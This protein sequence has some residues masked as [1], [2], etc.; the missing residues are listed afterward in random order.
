MSQQNRVKTKV[1]KPKTAPISYKS[2]LNTASLPVTQSYQPAQYYNDAMIYS[3]DY[4]AHPHV[5]QY[6]GEQL[7]PRGAPTKPSPPSTGSY[8]E[9]PQ[10]GGYLRSKGVDSSDV[11]PHNMLT[12]NYEPYKDSTPFTATGNN[13]LGSYPNAEVSNTVHVVY[14]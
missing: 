1:D 7:V 12:V 3:S 4:D 14:C 10:M 11:Y 9:Q 5:S 8:H 6:S 13:V 2:P